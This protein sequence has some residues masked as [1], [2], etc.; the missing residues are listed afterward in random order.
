VQ[1]NRCVSTKRSDTTPPTL[2]AMILP[3]VVQPDHTVTITVTADEALLA[4]PELSWGAYRATFVSQ[5]GVQYVFQLPI[6][7]GEPDATANVFATAF[8]EAGNQLRGAALGSLSV[9]GTVPALRGAAPLSFSIPAGCPRTP[10]ALG[11]TGMASLSFGVTEALAQDPIVTA[12]PL[13]FTATSDGA[14]G[15]TATASAPGASG[16]F[17]LLVALTDLAGN[18]ATLTVAQLQLDD[19]APAPLSGLVY[20]R[21]PY[22]A[23]PRFSVEGDAG[24]V[25]PGA[26]VELAAATDSTVLA[27]AVATADG[28]IS[29]PLFPNAIAALQARQWDTA[30]NGSAWAP[31]KRG[32]WVATMEGKIPG[33][34]AENADRVIFEANALPEGLINQSQGEA[35]KEVARADGT[36][37]S[38]SG[39]YTAIFLQSFQLPPPAQGEALAY[40]TARNRMVR[41]GGELGGP[42]RSDATW[43]WNGAAWAE[44]TPLLGSPLARASA[45]MT[46]DRRRGRTVL[47]GGVKSGFAGTLLQDTW[48]WNGS[49]WVNATPTTNNPPPRTSGAMAWD[50]TRNRV[51]LFGGGTWRDTWEWDGSAWM[52]ATPVTASPPA[53]SL[54][55]MAW[56]PVAGAVLLFVP[57][58][59]QTWKWTAG[60]WTDITPAG[61]PPPLMSASLAWNAG[62]SK[63]MLHGA[64]LSPASDNWEWSGTAWVNVSTVGSSVAG[65]LG[66][67]AARGKIVS[68]GGVRA[69]DWDGVTWA[70]KTPIPLAP[71][72][73][74]GDGLVFDSLRREVLLF[75]GRGAETSLWAWSGTEW[76][77]R[78]SANGLSPPGREQA[79]FAFDMARSTAVLFGGIS[80]P[81]T[82]DPLGD[83]WLWNGASWTQST[84]IPAPTPRWGSAMAFDPI[85][86][87]AVLFGGKDRQES[88]LNDTWAWDGTAW[89]NVTPPS[90]SPGPRDVHAMAWDASRNKI[91]LFGGYSETSPRAAGS[92]L[93]DTWEWDGAGWTK[94]STATVPGARYWTQLAFDTVRNHLVMMG[95]YPPTDQWELIGNDW[96]PI[97]P[98]LSPPI[99]STFGMTSDPVR[100]RLVMFGGEG[101]RGDSFGDTWEYDGVAWAD[102]T[103]AATLTSP[104]SR[105]YLASSYDSTRGRVVLFGGLQATGDGNDTWEWNGAWQKVAS[106]GPSARENAAMAFDA[107]RNRTVLFG[108]YD[109]DRLNDVWEW[110][111]ASWSAIPTPAVAPDPRYDPAM[112]YDP[113]GQRVMMWG[114][115]A[116]GAAADFWSWN[117][118][119]WTQ[120]QSAP[121]GRYSHAAAWD[122]TR[123]RLVSFGGHDDNGDL[124]GQTYEFTGASWKNATPAGASP[125]PR[126]YLSM[127]WD[128]HRERV[129]LY[130]AQ[131]FGF[132]SPNDVWEWTGSEWLRLFPEPVLQSSSSFYLGVHSM[133]PYG[134]DAVRSQFL[135]RPYPA[136][137]DKVAVVRATRPAA[138]I[139]VNLTRLGLPQGS[140]YQGATAELVFTAFGAKQTE[141]AA[142]DGVGWAVQGPAVSASPA[143]VDAPGIVKTWQQEAD[144][145]LRLQPSSLDTG[146]ILV[147]AVKVTVRY[148]L[149]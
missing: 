60:A 78:V 44:V 45:S 69:L 75:G 43:E 1:V 114:G 21:E 110:N 119:A 127:A 115:E 9:D 66:Y 94:L 6:P 118:S 29:V 12:G 128:P 37:L 52:N 79:A 131:D 142:F 47:F 25:D 56:D 106:G 55:A 53:T 7:K 51:V 147:D 27:E 133:V 68:V 141:L 57:Q 4:A 23:T 20:R 101:D 28:A 13:T 86:N 33:S 93:D 82:D 15:Y 92:P 97:V 134:L 129:V 34:T 49:V 10:A 103:P 46:Y 17:P 11:A 85:R 144:L 104:P 24:T 90:G 99:R 39:G 138:V 50:G 14:S 63:L 146:R 100:H 74:S 5:A 140:T 105:L 36:G 32:E 38:I 123:N 58:F 30:C 87:V 67:D 73:A 48:E 81:Y 143:V 80:V 83:T 148:T 59:G 16:T 31:I 113:V 116:F 111:G 41:F 62:R 35:G 2:T 132:A 89:T 120:L 54:G 76:N 139:D 18:S 112:A 135:V 102:K 71:L 42:L 96:S 149:P 40:D 121:V 145:Y 137:S 61:A 95:G 26:T 65:G 107:N 64:S 8:D 126:A 3:A 125:S 98:A 124:S 117:G 19:A 70:E 88:L 122:A 77:R 84:A 72:P 108:G 130:G 91:V 109:V 22:G 136:D